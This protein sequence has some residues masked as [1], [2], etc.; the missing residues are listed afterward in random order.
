MPV[1]LA[2]RGLRQEDG[3]SVEQPR[4]QNKILCHP[5]RQEKGER[6]RPRLK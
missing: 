3:W 4:L 6:A 5:Y 2:L 1:I